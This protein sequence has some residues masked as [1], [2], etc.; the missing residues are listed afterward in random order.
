MFQADHLVSD[1]KT[2]SQSS[3]FGLLWHF[4]HFQ[5]STR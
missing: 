4:V 2:S 5:Q 3:I 1:P